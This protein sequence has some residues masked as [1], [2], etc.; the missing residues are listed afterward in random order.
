MYPNDMT[1]QI[2]VDELSNSITNKYNET[3]QELSK[4]LNLRFAMLIYRLLKRGL[5]DP[6][7]IAQCAGMS[8]GNVYRVIEDLEKYLIDRKL[9][10]EVE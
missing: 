5:A 8:R 7:D 2:D 1:E 3:Y 9:V 4:S 10:Q 6:S